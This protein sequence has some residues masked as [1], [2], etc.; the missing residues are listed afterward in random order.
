M[1][2]LMHCAAAGLLGGVASCASGQVALL[3]QD[4]SISLQTGADGAIRTAM[5]ENFGPFAASVSHRAVVTD[6]FG[7]I[8]TGGDLNISC[9]F[10]GGIDLVATMTGWSL[11][12]TGVMAAPVTAEV[13]LDLAF[14]VDQPTQVWVLR[15]GMGSSQAVSEAVEVSLRRLDSQRRSLLSDSDA[16]IGSVWEQ[17][18]SLP[19]GEYEF[20]FHALLESTGELAQRQMLL[21]VRFDKPA[22]DADMNTDG[23]IDGADINAFFDVWETGEVGGDLNHD[24]GVDG[25]DVQFFL[26]HWEAG[27]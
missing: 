18:V 16:A 12:E 7:P 19:A 15:N 23:G 5:A 17:S 20:R 21:Q 11:S 22:C 24:G 13:N 25:M 14:S 1:N 27:C 4:R 6:P 3:T 10:E 9:H 2:R 8:D 26:E